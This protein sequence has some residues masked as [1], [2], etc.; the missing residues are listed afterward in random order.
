MH[1]NLAAIVLWLGAPQRHVHLLQ[2]AGQEVFGDSVV[3]VS[4]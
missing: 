1:R 4:A 3:L 2:H